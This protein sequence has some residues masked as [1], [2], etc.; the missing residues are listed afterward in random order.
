[1]G[2]ALGTPEDEGGAGNR[3][4]AW[5]TPLED[6]ETGRH[7]DAQ[8]MPVGGRAGHAHHASG[9]VAEQ[10]DSS[11]PIDQLKTSRA[12][13]TQGSRPFGPGLLPPGRLGDQQ[14]EPEGQR[15]ARRAPSTQ[16]ARSISPGLPPLPSLGLKDHQREPE[17]Q[18]IA[19][20]S[21]ALS[22]VCGAGARHAG[23]L[24]A[25][26]Y[27]LFEVDLRGV[28]QEQLKL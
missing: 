21:S 24:E 6:E 12:P 20:S 19:K 23:W 7:G 11:R 25:Q 9:P 5:A 22:T 16:G 18:G 17:S 3:V 28:P 4:Q 15:S 26:P 14:R 10:V 27:A 8:A 2:A 1:M 13:S